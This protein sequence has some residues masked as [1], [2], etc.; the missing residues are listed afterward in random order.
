MFKTTDDLERECIL[1][2][3]FLG[4]AF[5]KW[6]SWGV[7][8]R[9]ALLLKIFGRVHRA[10]FSATFAA[11]TRGREGELRAMSALCASPPLLMGEAQC[12]RSVS[13]IDLRSQRK[14]QL[15]MNF[16]GK[17]YQKIIKSK[18]ST[19]GPDFSKYL[20]VKFIFLIK[21][22]NLMKFEIYV[23]FY[24]IWNNM[25]INCHQIHS[26]PSFLQNQP[27]ILTPVVKVPR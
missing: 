9:E 23:S 24:T 8:L 22:D 7:I 1:G 20:Q 16:W 11:D 26:Q 5:L 2:N 6:F 19:E 4:E 17:S 21:Q 10:T 27:K 18:K 25:T 12:S 13:K 15:D 14:F 3:L